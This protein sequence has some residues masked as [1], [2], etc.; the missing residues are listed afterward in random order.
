MNVFDAVER[1]SDQESCI[2]HLETIRRGGKPKCP[3]CESDHVAPKQEGDKVE[4]VE[5]P[6]LQVEFQCFI[7]HL[8]SRYTGSAS[9]VVSGYLAYE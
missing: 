4:T 6:L 8:V 9:E 2:K 7:R 5:L 1:F 3:Y